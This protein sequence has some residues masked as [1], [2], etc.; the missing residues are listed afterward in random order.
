[1][2]TIICLL[3]LLSAAAAAP[4]EVT[5]SGRVVGPDG[6]PIAGARVGV[7]TA[8]RPTVA[9][10]DTRSADDGSFEVAIEGPMPEGA[11]L[12]AA[13][14]E[15]FAAG[16]AIGVIGQRLEVTLSDDPGSVSGT[17]SGPD[18]EPLEGVKVRVFVLYAEGEA[19]LG[20][21]FEGWDGAPQALTD[22]R[23]QFTIGDLPRG[24]KVA[25]AAEAEGLAEWRAMDL[26]AWPVVGQ[27]VPVSMA[28]EPEAVI[29]GRVTRQGEPAA[30]VAVNAQAQHP[31]VGRAHALT[32]NTGRYE[33]RS[34]AGGTYNVTIDPPEGW[35][36]AAR[37]SVQVASGGR[38]EGIDLELIRGALVRGTVTWQETGEPVAGTGVGAYGPAGPQSTGAVQRVVTDD[39]GRYELR[40]PP[41]HSRIY[42]M[43][44]TDG[45][46][47]AQPDAHSIE[48]GADEVREGMD[49]ELLGTRTI[50]LSV[51][52]PDGGP[53][54]GVAIHWTGAQ[55]FGLPGASEPIVT[56]EDGRVELTFGREVDEWQ[57]PLVP[58]LAQDIERDLAGLAIINGETD[59]EATITLEPAAWAVVETRTRGDEPLADIP[60][61]VRWNTPGWGDDLPL[62][63][64]TDDQGRARIG[65]LPPGV[66]LTVQPSWEYRNRVLAPAAD[67]G[68]APVELEPGETRELEPFVIV[69]EGF[70]LRG[71]VIDAAGEPVEGAVVVCANS[72][73]MRPVRVEADA[74]GRFELTGLGTRDATFVMA[75]SPDGS[76]AWAEPVDPSV[77][78]EPTI[79]LGTPGTI[80]ATFVGADGRAAPDLTVQVSG[81]E[82]RLPP[83][84]ELPGDLKGFVRD[85]RTDAQGQVRV[86]GLVPGVEYHV[87][88]RA[89]GAEGGHWSSSEPV[90]ILGDGATVEVTVTLR[91]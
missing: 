30:G 78:F 61:M 42:W 87:L 90:M 19:P 48:L 76:A 25:L 58:A 36:A 57:K 79:Q 64:S 32:D 15:G 35:T 77:A 7:V 13:R 51:R 9:W 11:C 80:V 17:V 67:E 60:F 23:G 68:R 49:F 73:S 71:T 26:T 18:G 45:A 5:V 46:R 8:V 70:S 65:P 74:E 31:G 22:E 72:I 38:A 29:T 44:G 34:L 86:E 85:L 1:M 10:I 16:G 43:G 52:N 53:A 59:T 47:C 12:V 40:V 33:M 81:Q 20:A 84:T 3:A 14:A 24:Q 27:D 41:G 89:A 39:E 55:A 62:R 28:M 91:G 2:R 54:A 88:G 75:A 6:E 4:D 50:S 82:L 83:G 69:P 56:D 21:W 37:E 66:S 63:T